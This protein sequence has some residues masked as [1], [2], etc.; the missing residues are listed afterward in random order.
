VVF[1]VHPLGD[2]VLRLTY[3]YPQGDDS[4]QRVQNQLFSVFG[5]LEAVEANPDPAADTADTGDA[6]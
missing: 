2:R 5:E 1:T 3:V 6:G 4:A